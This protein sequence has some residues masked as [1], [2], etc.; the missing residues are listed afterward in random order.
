MED[1]VSAQRDLPR[2][3][4]DRFA[5]RSVLVTGHNGFVGT[6]LCALL[7]ALGSEVFGLSLPRYARPW[8]DERLVD[9]DHEFIG[10]IRDLEFVEKVVSDSSP[11]FVFHLAAQPIVLAS[12]DDPVGTFA[13]NVL[14]TTHVLEAARRSSSTRT[15]VI[16]TSD[17]CYAPAFSPRREDDPL[18]GDDP[19]S[20]SKAGAELVASAYWHSFGTRRPLGIATA[21]A[22]NI[23][24]G[25]DWSDHR[26]VPDFVRAY[27]AEMP[28]TIRNPSAIRPWQHVLD[29]V[30]GYVQLASFLDHDPSGV[31]QAWN[32]GPNADEP[33]TVA[34]LIDRL[35]AS[36]TSLAGS[37]VDV[38]YGAVDPTSIELGYLSLDAGKAKAVLGWSNHLSLDDAA[39]LST[40]WYHSVL[41]TRT[42]SAQEATADQ[43]RNYLGAILAG[44]ELT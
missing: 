19:Y 29:A 13:T 31:S 22:G 43:V 27:Q 17:K 23:V 35:Q 4:S 25:G 24:G 1:L 9:R 37:P 33:V 32:F 2:H 34:E 3:V 28:L 44:T 14:G 39:Q 7:Q 41:A 36:W 30:G 21:R 20:A 26:I 8:D 10:D 16:V 12:L 38:E 5:D 42:R 40:E 18:G 15:C 6:W 11:E